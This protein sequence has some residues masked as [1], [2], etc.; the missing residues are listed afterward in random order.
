[1]DCKKEA[2]KVDLVKGAE[3][4]EFTKVLEDLQA[5]EEIYKEK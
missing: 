4:A 2:R 3:I 1:M 5:V